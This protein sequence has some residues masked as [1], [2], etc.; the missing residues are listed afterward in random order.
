[1]TTELKPCPFCGSATAPTVITWDEMTWLEH[2]YH[3]GGNA[4]ICDVLAGGCGS[5]TGWNSAESN[6]FN[7]STEADAI[8]AWN[9]RAK[10]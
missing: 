7:T 3:S 8:A 10:A 4:V 6:D 5:M 1:M 2:E 9:R